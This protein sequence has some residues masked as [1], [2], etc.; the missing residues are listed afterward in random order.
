MST[1]Y[2]HATRTEKKPKKPQPFSIQP[3]PQPNSYGWEGSDLKNK[4]QRT[5]ITSWGRGS[6]PPKLS[7]DHD[8]PKSKFGGLWVSRRQSTPR[9]VDR[10]SRNRAGPWHQGPQRN[11]EKRESLQGGR[12]P[13]AP[14]SRWKSTSRI[15]LLFLPLLPARGPPPTQGS[16]STPLILSRATPSPFLP[17]AWT[18]LHWGSELP[19]PPAFQFVPALP[20]RGRRAGLERP[21]ATIK[22]SPG[23]A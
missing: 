21:S 6:R 19:W 5:E 4:K 1:Y 18:L 20:S 13:E 3:Q 16:F 15:G 17:L 22:R 2:V 10:C 7:T 8:K 14:A 11:W 12:L 9:G 23:E